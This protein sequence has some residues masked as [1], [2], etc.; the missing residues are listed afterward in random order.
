MTSGWR[1]WRHVDVIFPHNVSRP[2]HEKTCFM[3]YANY[4]DTDQQAHPGSLISTFVVHCLDS[5]I[6][7]LAKSKIWRLCLISAAEQAP[8]HKVWK[9]GVLMIWLIFFLSFRMR[10]SPWQVDEWMFPVQ[11]S[12]FR[13]SKTALVRLYISLATSREDLS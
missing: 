5:I 13:I 8:G 10:Y 9:T 2:H 12:S 7:I 3:V 1:F 6:P 4:K 11:L